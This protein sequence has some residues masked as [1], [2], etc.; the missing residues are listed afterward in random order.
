MRLSTAV[1]AFLILSSADDAAAAEQ[2]KL[3]GTTEVNG[4][5]GEERKCGLW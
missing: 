3:V 2:R 5:C 4:D 1:T